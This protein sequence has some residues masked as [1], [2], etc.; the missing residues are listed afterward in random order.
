MSSIIAAVLAELSASTWPRRVAALEQLRQ[1]LETH[2]SS[3]QLLTLHEPLL[4]LVHDPAWKVRHALI[5]V[6]STT[7]GSLGLPQALVI[8]AEDTNRYVREAARRLQRQR[9]RARVARWRRFT[10]KDDPVF[11][12]IHQEIR[13]ANGNSLPEALLYRI[14]ERAAGIAYRTAVRDL[15]HELNT[16]LLGADLS[17]QQIVRRLEALNQP[18]AK[19]AALVEKMA[20]RTRMARRMVADVRCYAVERSHDWQELS[21]QALLW[22]AAELA[23]E[24]ALNG[25][26]LPELRILPLPQCLVPVLPDRMRRALTNLICNALE[27]TP[28]YGEV[29]VTTTLSAHDVTIL[30]RDSGHGFT[31]EDLEKATHC[32]SSTKRGRGGT[33]MG[34]PIALQIIEA[35][36][37]GQLDIDSQ[38]GEGTTVRV[39]L[40]RTRREQSHE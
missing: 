27:A 25:G 33:G 13:Q 21:L 31:E 4:A 20:E 10:G 39:V 38:F 16:I 22:P 17:A 18:D 7:S 34:L 2:P 12:T 6:L 11:C 1:Y 24:A 37:D 40:P 9:Q 36:H 14:T 19:V 23:Q 5:G 29:V 15:T 3:K 28:P 30:I 26:L 8:L 32:F 35:E